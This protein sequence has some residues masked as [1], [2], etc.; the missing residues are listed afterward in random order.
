MA[1]Q[2]LQLLCHPRGIRYS[3]GRPTCLNRNGRLRALRPAAAARHAEGRKRHDGR[4]GSSLAARLAETELDFHMGRNDLRCHNQNFMSRTTRLPC[5]DTPFIDR[6]ADDI[7]YVTDPCRN[8]RAVPLLQWKR[9]LHDRSGY[10]LRAMPH[11][12]R[13]HT[14]LALDRLDS[15]AVLRI[16]ASAATEPRTQCSAHRR[17]AGHIAVLSVADDADGTTLVSIRK[18]S[19]PAA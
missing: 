19:V 7:Q 17:R 16:S 18:K 11:D 5:C 12:F 1:L 9:L 2:H 14:R 13:A 4:R 15:G 8:C 3:R 10:N 6:F